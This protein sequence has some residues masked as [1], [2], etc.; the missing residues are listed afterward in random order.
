MDFFI[1]HC[2]QWL[3]KVP[4]V[5]N[6]GFIPWPLGPGVVFEID[7]QRLNWRRTNETSLN[8]SIFVI[9]HCLQWL[10]KVPSLDD[11]GFIPWPLGPSV[12]FEIDKQRLNWLRTNATSL[13]TWIFVINYCLPWLYKVPSLNDG[14]FIPWPLGPSVVFEIDKQRLNWRRTN[15]TSLNTWIFVINYYLQWLYKVPSLDDGG[16]I[17]WPLG[18][19]VVFEI[20]KQRLNWRRTNET[21]L[22]TWIFV[23]NHCLQWL[24]KVPS[25]DNCGFIPWPLGPSVVF[26]IDK[27]RLN[28]RRANATSLKTWIF[29]INYCLQLLFKVPSLDDGG[30]IPWPLGASVV[31]EIDKRRLNWRLTSITSLNTW[32]FLAAS[33]QLYEWYFPSVCLLHLFDYVPIIVSSWNFQELLSMTKVTSMQKV[34]VRG[35][36]SRSNPT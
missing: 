17:P 14:G 5:D 3:Y 9:S 25:V 31:F 28:W 15:E 34:K 1:N 33:K 7:K 30:F 35:Q 29:V 2:L 13:K 23:I 22:N 19:S 24:Y 12:V 10:Y 16:F 11:G 18:P 6:C 20:D 27:R 26:E 32:I 36:R 8:V 4:N 21:S